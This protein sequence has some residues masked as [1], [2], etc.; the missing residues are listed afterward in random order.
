MLGKAPTWMT[1]CAEADSATSRKNDAAITNRLVMALFPSSVQ[2]HGQHTGFFLFLGAT[3]GT[4]RHLVHQVGQ[5]R[6]VEDLCGRVADVE[7]YLIQRAMVSIAS[8]QAAQLFR[9]AERRQRTV[10]EPDN[11]AQADFSGWTPQRISAL[12]AAD[13]LHDAGILQFEEN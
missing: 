4:G 13:A 11:F 1:V 2:H 8:D 3:S 12:G 7:K 10:D 9:I 5:S 6:V